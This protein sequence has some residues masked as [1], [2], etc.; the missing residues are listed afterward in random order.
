MA[1]LSKGQAGPAI[2]HVVARLAQAIDDRGLLCE[3]P[4]LRAR[5]VFDM[6]RFAVRV[7]QGA[8][9]KE[10]YIDECHKLLN[11]G[12]LQS[13]AEILR[14]QQQLLG[15]EISWGPYASTTGSPCIEPATGTRTPS[16]D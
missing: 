16:G 6:G 9:G 11:G 15:P 14:S 12:G 5:R 10:V 3:T 4:T 7:H 8:Y 1:H 13:V 2:R